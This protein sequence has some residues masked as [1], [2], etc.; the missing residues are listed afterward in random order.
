M[1]ADFSSAREITASGIVM[2][3]LVDDS[4]ET[5]FRWRAGRLEVLS[6]VD[7]AR[8]RAVHEAG[9]VLVLGES[10]AGDGDRVYVW[11]P[12]GS[13]TALSPELAATP[14]DLAEDGTVVGDLAAPGG[15]RAALWRD[16]VPQVLLPDGTESW[17]APEGAVN[18]RREVAG[19]A[20]SDGRVRAF[21]WRDG[22]VRYLDLPGDAVST[23]VDINERGQVLVQ[24]AS[25][26]LLL[27]EPD[28]SV[29]T[30]SADPAVTVDPDALDDRGRVVG[31]LFED[32]VA[33]RYPA[34]VDQRGC[35]PAAGPGRSHRQRRRRE[36]PRR[37][38]R[39]GGP[40]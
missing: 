36:P 8:P 27:W 15:T 17:L 14:V 3:Y 10:P 33:T 32:D 5:A 25:S 21:V 24:G 31:A 30:L 9:Q 22:Q 11:E 16:G 40:G 34:F 37:D 12:G 18:A 28:G 1:D 2:G 35:A 29:R 19:T 38:G 26:E 39:L 13:A 6:G 23:A 20:R 4:R 7:V